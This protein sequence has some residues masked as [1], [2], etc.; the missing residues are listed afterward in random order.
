MDSKILAAE[1]KR[2]KPGSHNP[3]RHRDHRATP[4]PPSPGSCGS[5]VPPTRR[6]SPPKPPR[7]IPRPHLSLPAAAAAPAPWPGRFL[8][9]RRAFLREWTNRQARARRGS[10]TA[11]GRPP[12]TRS[13]HP[14]LTPRASHYRENLPRQLDRMA[15]AEPDPSPGPGPRPR[16]PPLPPR[17][18]RGAAPSALP[19]APMTPSTA[20]TGS[21]RPPA[22]PANGERRP[23]RR[24]AVDGCGWRRGTHCAGS[25]A[26]DGG[27]KRPR[28]QRDFREHG[29]SGAEGDPENTVRPGTSGRAPAFRD[30]FGPHRGCGETPGV[31]VGIPG[32]RWDPRG[33]AVRRD[34]G[35][36]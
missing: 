1:V 9:L 6:Q 29:T 20:S 7:S 35:E 19:G 28:G 17:P 33:N 14:A 8:W 27:G 21:S 13:S 25:G 18:G 30:L 2:R 5:P 10:G 3:R 34:E 16:P 26:Q 11:R 32:V 12:V 22:R 15:P 23:K 31:G 24:M 4:G 36:G